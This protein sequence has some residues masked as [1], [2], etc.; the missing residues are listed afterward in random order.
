[1]RTTFE[2][3]ENQVPEGWFNIW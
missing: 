2:T 3:K 1:M